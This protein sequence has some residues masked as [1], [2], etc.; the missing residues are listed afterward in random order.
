VIEIGRKA[1]EIFE[2]F[3]EVSAVLDGDQSFEDGTWSR[4]VQVLTKS[5]VSS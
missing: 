5:H 3:I 2:H 4:G 1:R